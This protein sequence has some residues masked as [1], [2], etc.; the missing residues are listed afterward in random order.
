ML[1]TKC[2]QDDGAIQGH[3]LPASCCHGIMIVLAGLWNLF[4]SIVKA[5]YGNLRPMSLNWLEKRAG[6]THGTL[7]IDPEENSL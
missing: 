6:V 5:L 3:P 7:K 2:R 4:V 1:G